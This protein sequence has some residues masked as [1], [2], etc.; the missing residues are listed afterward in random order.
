MRC[1]LAGREY[2]IFG[3][4]GKQVRDAIHSQDLV[5][6]FDCVVRE[7]RVGEVYNIGGGRQSNCSVLEAIALVSEITG[8]ELQ[9]RYDER[10][11]IAR[12]LHGLVV[13]SVE[14]MGMY[15]GRPYRMPS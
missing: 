10:N 9:W 14:R 8:R 11:R 3:Y 6:A 2:T 1:A 12:D 4:K 13:R 15:R 5:R 7:P